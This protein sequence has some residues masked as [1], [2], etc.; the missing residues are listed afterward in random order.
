M[1]TFKDLL[2]LLSIGTEIQSPVYSGLGYIAKTDKENN[3]YDRYELTKLSY[4]SYE[5]M[6]MYRHDTLKLEG[7]YSKIAS[8]AKDVNLQDLLDIID[9]YQYIRIK[10]RVGEELFYDYRKNFCI[11]EL[12]TSIAKHILSIQLPYIEDRCKV[13]KRGVIEIE[14][15]VKEDYVAEQELDRCLAM[16]TNFAV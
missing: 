13:H 16:I 8:K 10:S 9:E 11:D 6:G 4:N 1:I 12:K 5:D 3:S 2:P 15:S 14:I 7:T